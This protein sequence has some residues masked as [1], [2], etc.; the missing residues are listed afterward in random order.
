M[1]SEVFG[2]LIQ[3]A[4]TMY[5]RQGELPIVRLP[6]MRIPSPRVHVTTAAGRDQAVRHWRR[7]NAEVHSAARRLGRVRGLV[8]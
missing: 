6:P 3:E 7:R 2:S 1:F 8:S 4:T 5:R